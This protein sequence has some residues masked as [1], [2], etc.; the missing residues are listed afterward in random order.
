MEQGAERMRT[1]A[2][3]AH[4]R[5]FSLI[6]LLT[7]VVILLITLSLTVP[8]ISDILKA[9]S[10]TNAGEQVISTLNIARQTAIALN[11]TVEV[12]IYR[13]EL[14]GETT[15]GRFRG[16]Q[17][18]VLEQSENGDSS[19]P[20]GRKAALP[21][22]ICITANPSL[23]SLLDPATTSQSTGNELSFPISPSGLDYEAAKFRFFPDGSTNLPNTH[24]HFLTLVHENTTDSISNPPENFAT[25][26]IDRTTGKI[27]LHRPQ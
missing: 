23:S 10:L 24:P 25:I 27:Q 26:L 18:F 21:S 15:P 4:R 14:P 1:A 5:G 19:I 9:S 11:R 3:K 17:A 16:I 8:A 6:E 22:R 7:V 20:I 12:R 2:R 13:Y